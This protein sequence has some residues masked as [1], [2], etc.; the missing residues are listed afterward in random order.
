MSSGHLFLIRVLRKETA[1]STFDRL[2]F[3]QKLSDSLILTIVLD[4]GRLAYVLNRRIPVECG[5]RG[6]IGKRFFPASA[7]GSSGGD[8]MDSNHKRELFAVAVQCE[9]LLESLE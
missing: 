6:L 2:Y 4:S 5:S 3:C 9:Q 8:M 1:A 7:F